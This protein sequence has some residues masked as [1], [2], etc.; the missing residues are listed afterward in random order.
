MKRDFEKTPKKTISRLQ[1]LVEYNKWGVRFGISERTIKMKNYLNRLAIKENMP[2][3]IFQ[4]DD[5]WYIKIK[6][7]TYEFD[8]SLFLFD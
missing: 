3:R 2:Y 7:V 1:K 4:Q 8:N 6:T 5:I